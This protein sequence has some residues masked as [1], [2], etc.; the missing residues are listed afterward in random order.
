M[1]EHG[2][3]DAQT[4]NEFEEQ[5][6]EVCQESQELSLCFPAYAET[7][8]RKGVMKG[9]GKSRQSWRTGL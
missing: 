1:A 8:S 4:V 2:D 7:R 5:L 9:F 3:E 6:I